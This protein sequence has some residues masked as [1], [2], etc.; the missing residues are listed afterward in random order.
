MVVEDGVMDLAEYC[1]GMALYGVSSIA[2]TEAYHVI[3]GVSGL[4]RF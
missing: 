1:D 3:A 4:F 2:A